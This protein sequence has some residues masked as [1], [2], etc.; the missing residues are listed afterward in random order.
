MNRRSAWKPVLENVHRRLESW[1]AKILSRAGRLTLIK[2]VLNSFPVY[3]M[4]MFKLSKSVAQQIVGLQRNFFWSGATSEKRGCPRIGWSDIEL[5]KEMGGLGVGNIMH[6]NLILLFKWW[7]RFSETDNSLWKR[8]LNSVHDINGLKASS[9]TFQKFKGGTWAQLLST[10]ADTSKMRS[11]IE[12]GIYVKIGKGNSVQ[13]WHDNWCEGGIL[14]RAFP[15][16]YTLSLQKNHLVNQ[17]GV[18]PESS[19]AW[20]LTW[21]RSLYVWEYEEVQRLETIIQQSIPDAHT[22]DCVV[23]KHSAAGYIPRKSL[24]RNCLKAESPSYPKQ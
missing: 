8:I 17:M 6:K 22:E 21:R 7:W 19:W 23:W 14:K 1:K 18:W 20:L 13:F 5:P 16:L 3:Y 12:E 24:T 2:S 9:D 11:I 4:S 10:D 15:R